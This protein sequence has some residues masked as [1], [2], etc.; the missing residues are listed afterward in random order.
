MRKRM[1]TRSLES[2]LIIGT[3]ALALPSAIA[4]R[5]QADEKQAAVSAKPPQLAEDLI[6]TWV[7]V[8][9]PDKVGE[10]P[11]A[12]G[13]LKFITGRHFAVTQ[14]DPETGAVI[15][16]HGGT[17][18]LDGDNYAETIDYANQSTA[19]L[20]KQT[21]NFKVK[22]EGD[23]LTLIGIGNPFKEVWKRAK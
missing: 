8:G 12:G 18:K 14:S 7:L 22:V 3:L 19:D 10:P 21:F 13:R 16:H 17:Y 4:S 1:T 23:S 2:A 9:T 11:N 20:I 6:G 5:L 15:H